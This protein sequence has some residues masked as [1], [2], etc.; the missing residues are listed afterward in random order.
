MRLHAT[1]WSS[2]Q[3]TLLG[4]RRTDKRDSVAFVV[5][6]G[7]ASK[8]GAASASGRSLPSPSVKACVPS[9]SPNSQLTVAA[10]AHPRHRIYPH[11]NQ[12]PRHRL[13]AGKASGFADEQ[14][15]CRHPRLHFVGIA[16][17]GERMLS[18]AKTR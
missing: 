4:G 5:S 11:G 10:T 2:S 8:A 1:P 3:L 18:L 6:P 17:D 13:G 7:S 14:V 12:A 15:G 9:R 16:E